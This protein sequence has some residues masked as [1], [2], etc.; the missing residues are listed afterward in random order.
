MYRVKVTG[1]EKQRIKL[2]R[3][4]GHSRATPARYKASLLL[5]AHFMTPPHAVL[6]AGTSASIQGTAV[7]AGAP[8]SQQTCT[9]DIW[10]Y[11]LLKQN[12]GQKLWLS[13]FSRT[14]FQ[15]TLWRQ[16]LQRNHVG[17]EIRVTTFWCYAPS[18]AITE[19]LAIPHSRIRMCQKKH[20][21][22][23]LPFEK[24]YCQTK[25]IF[26]FFTLTS[27]Y[28]QHLRQIINR[29]RKRF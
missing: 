13:L 20:M 29:Y 24:K 9:H 16:A 22:A 23:V 4:G 10:R 1:W 3:L 21:L 11:L 26:L 18:L 28:T 14:K 5:L 12:K 17:L 27:D 25:I 19:R 15:S 6:A 7:T 2:I 8:F